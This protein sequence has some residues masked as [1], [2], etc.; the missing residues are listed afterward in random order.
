MPTPATTKNLTGL[1]SGT[2]YEYRVTAIG[3]G[4]T[5]LDSDPSAVST[6]TTLIPLAVPTG[7]TLTKT[8][9]TVTA[10]WN[11]VT[12]ATGYIVAWVSGNGTWTE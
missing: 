10:T 8:S 1:T 4:T 6:F 11:A 9:T 3:D 5:Y 2:A 7:L 12:N